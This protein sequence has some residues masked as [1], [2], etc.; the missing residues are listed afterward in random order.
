MYRFRRLFLFVVIVLLSQ[1]SLA[2]NYG[3][4]DSRYRS[5]PYDS[6]HYPNQNSNG[7][8]SDYTQRNWFYNKQ[9]ALAKDPNFDP[10][11]PGYSTNHTGIKYDRIYD[12]ESRLRDW[13]NDPNL[14]KADRGWIRQEIARVDHN[15][16]LG[17]KAKDT[18]RNPPGKDLAHQRGRENGKGYGLNY[19]NLQN[20]DLHMLQHTG[21]LDGN[22]MRDKDKPDLGG[23]RFGILNKERVPPAYEA[24]IGNSTRHWD[25]GHRSAVRNASR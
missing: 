14:G 8:N 25:A 4:I 24:A 7:A 13:A 18:M 15:R 20:H 11:R 3:S 1:Q 12:K 21:K 17:I 2:D 9:A 19:A 23:D 6:R 22:Y 5:K 10:N 16:S